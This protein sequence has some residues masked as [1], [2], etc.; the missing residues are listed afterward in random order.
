MTM[1]A[2]DAA[3][4]S[5]PAEVGAVAAELEAAGFDGAYAFEGQHDPFMVLAAAAA[6]TQ[7]MQL[8][9]SIAVAFARNPMNIAYLANDL[10]L[11]SEGRFILG[12]GTQVK[13]HIERRFSMPWSKPAARMREMVLALKEIWRV[14]ETG[15][16]LS[17]E[18][19]FY[20]HTLMAP[21]FSPGANPHGLPPIYIA[22]V[23]PLM[24]K[25]AAEVAEGLFVHPFGSARS[26]REL[27]MPAVEAG[28]EAGGKSRDDFTI[29]V[30]VITAT[31]TNEEELEMATFSAR[32]QIGFYASTPAYLPV[33]QVHGWE[34]LQVEAQKLVKAGDWNG[35]ASLVDDEV[36]NT[37]AVV[38]EPDAV[39]AGIR[40]RMGDIADRVS[41]VAYSTSPEPLRALLEA[42]RA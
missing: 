39:A 16:R 27:T 23:G 34:E 24:T 14:W 17:F 25:T 26:I 15:E 18:G 13:A 36:L 30:Q 8:M 20:S 7:R 29:A 12:L 40:E 19:E 21:T 10:Q 6:T 32:N 37:F 2:I 38:G 4:M 9:T 5:N 1:Y 33:L 42:M 3:M 31:G 35:L 41:P 11:M 22:G 28:L